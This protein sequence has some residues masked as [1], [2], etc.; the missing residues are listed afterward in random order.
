MAS[1]LESVFN[2]VVLPPKLPGCRDSNGRAV[3]DNLLTRLLGACEALSTLPGQGAQSCWEFVRQQLLYAS[4]STGAALTERQY[5]A[6]S[7]TCQLTTSDMVTPMSSDGGDSNVVFETFEGSPSSEAVLAAEGALQWDF[8]GRAA[9]IPLAAFSDPSFTETLATFLEQ[10]STEALDRF[11]ARSRKAGASIL[12]TRDS[13]NPALISQMLLPL[14]EAIGSLVHVPMLRN[15]FDLWVKL[16]ED[17]VAKFPLLLDYYPGFSPK[18]L[19]ILQ[20]T[21]VQDIKRLRRIQGHLRDRCQRCHFGSKTIISGLS[22]EY[23]AAWFMVESTDLQS[24]QRQIEAESHKARVEAKSRWRKAYDEYDALTVCLDEISYTCLK[25]PNGAYGAYNSNWAYRDVHVVFRDVSFCTYLAEQIERRLSTIR[26]NWR[27][28]YCIE[29]LITMS[30]RLLWL[31]GLDGRSAVER[32]Y[33]AESG[34]GET[35][36]RY[37]LWASLFYQR[38]FVVLGHA[39]VDMSTKELEDFD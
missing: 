20:L 12:E 10:V 5:D 14:L 4:T 24:L 21:T 13:V 8:P 3:E 30:L 31:A 35:A 7:P 16:D 23:F 1:L 38:T 9:R 15:I 2:H 11:V 28:V 33:Y 6:H 17:I 26:T 34:V 27:E 29:T 36:A 32:W 25:M 22:R 39:G 19:D 37:C 18:L